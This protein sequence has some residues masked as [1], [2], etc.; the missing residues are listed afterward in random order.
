MQS[1]RREIILVGEHTG[2]DVLA[3]KLIPS[4]FWFEVGLGMVGI[5]MR[6]ASARFRVW[7][8]L[9]C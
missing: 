8:V 5:G 9:T 4:C 2:N 1:G 3:G 7:A 6:A